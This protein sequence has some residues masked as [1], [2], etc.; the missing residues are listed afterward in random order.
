[1]SNVIIYGDELYHHG[2][3]G[4][5]WGQRRYQDEKGRL[6]AEGRRRQ[7]IDAAKQDYKNARRAYN[8]AVLTDPREWFGVDP[9]SNY[10][11]RDSKLE[12]L[13]NKAL[14]KKAALA[15]A[16]KGS[17][18]E[19]RVYANKMYR[20]GEVGSLTDVASGGKSKK[21]YNRLKAEKGKKYADAV[22]KKVHKKNVAVFATSAAISVGSYLAGQYL[23]NKIDDD[24][25]SGWRNYTAR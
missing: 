17:D 4:M 21:L 25:R 9:N 20:T 18:A 11:K 16:K 14:D 8:K 10:K 23:Q 22:V 24:F 1:M 2:V 7:K 6:T 15:K 19:M 5:K 3:K 13:E 12:R